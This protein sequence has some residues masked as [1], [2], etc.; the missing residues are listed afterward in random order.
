MRHSNVSSSRRC[1]TPSSP[2]L[3]ST[4][5]PRSASKRSS[6]SSPSLPTKF[7]NNVLDA[8]KAFSRVLT[9]P[10]RSQGCPDTL[11]GGDRRR[12]RGGAGPGTSPSTRRCSSP[13][14]S[15]AAGAIC[16][17][18]SIARSS[19]A[20]RR[21]SA[22]TCRS[23]SASC[24]CARRRPS[25]SDTLRIAEVSLAS[26]MAPGVGGGREAA[27]RAPRGAR[28]RVRAASSPS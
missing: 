12:A 24:S 22:T 11:L 1:A 26:K 20:L 10:T 15:T 17:S 4:G 21:A 13:S 23:S 5:A 25:S 27:R 19:P 3:V 8:T 2:A 9:S 18:S 14:W 6:S 7:T 28:C 16:A